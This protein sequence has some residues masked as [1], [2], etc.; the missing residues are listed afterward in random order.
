MVKKKNSK[1][2]TH[3][4]PKRTQR[5]ILGA[6]AAAAVGAVGLM[7]LVFPTKNDNMSGVG[8]NGFSVFE[9]KGA[10][11]GIA[12]VADK[13]VVETALGKNAKSVDDVE[14]SGVISLNG[15]LGQTAT[16]PFTLKDGSKATI[17]IDVLQYKSK[18]T[19]D[20]DN[21]FKGTGLAG[22]IDGREIRYIPASSIGKDRTY[23]LL[24]TK[25]LKSYKFEMSQPNTKVLIK[26]YLAQ[27]ILKAI[28]AKSDL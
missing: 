11:L 24:V 14:K 1:K 13:R 27:D 20:G 18:E 8:S 22:K 5:V 16:Y 6:V 21:V 17:D 9:K 19:Y 15:S 4:D 23:A 3:T 28:I 10:D 25:D 26:E 2:A 12:D 7:V